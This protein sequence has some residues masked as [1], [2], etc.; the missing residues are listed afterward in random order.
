MGNPT[1]D[2]DAADAADKS[3]ESELRG[4]ALDGSEQKRA[5]GHTAFKKGHN[6]DTV[7]RVD[8][9][10]DTLYTDGLELDDETPPLGTAGR[11][12]DNAR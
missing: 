5:A 6:P 9:E 12:E 1:T 11:S 10:K 7:L 4:A 3:G 8:D 2:G